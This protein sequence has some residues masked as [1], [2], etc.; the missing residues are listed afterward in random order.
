MTGYQYERMNSIYHTGCLKDFK[1]ELLNISL[2]L[3]KDYQDGKPTIF[4]LE[5]LKQEITKV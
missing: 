1:Q 3:I 4:K 5:I 2:D